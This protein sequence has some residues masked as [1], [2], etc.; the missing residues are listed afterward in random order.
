MAKIYR[1]P[2]EVGKAPNFED[3]RREDGSFDIEAEL[4]AEKE[5]VNKIVEWCKRH[6][7]SDLAGYIWRYPVADGY[8]QYV[9]YRTK[10]LELIWIETG[11]A[12]NINDIVARGLRVGDIRQAK[13]FDEIWAKAVKEG[14]DEARH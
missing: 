8:A 4:A 1:A 6:S 10:P 7:K 2:K 13:K 5:Y 12:W 3:F 14:K 11:D 9:V